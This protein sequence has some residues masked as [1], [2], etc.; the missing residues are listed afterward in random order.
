MTTAHN[1]LTRAKPGHIGGI[2]LLVLCLCIVSTAVARDTGTGLLRLQ[3][4][5]LEIK[6]YTY[7]P[8]TCTKPSLLFVFHGLKRNA[9]SYRNKAMDIASRAC[10]MVFAP[11]FDKD[12]FPNWRYQRA[13]V[14]RKGHVQ[15]RSQ[16]T[17]PVLRALLDLA[18]NQ[19]NNPDAK[20]YLFG[21]SAGAQFL[22]RISAYSPLS[23]VDRVVIANPSVHVAP[24]LSEDA[25]Y[26][27]GGVSSAEQVEAD[28]MAYL[29]SPI[30]IYLGQ[31]DTGEK[32]LVKSAAAMRQGKNRFERG[33]RIFSMA[34]ELARLRGW[35]FEWQLVEVPGVGHSSGKMLRAPELYLALGL[36]SRTPKIFDS[37]AHLLKPET[38]AKNIAP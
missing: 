15:P 24:L 35:P 34:Q 22:S 17:A 2:L 8:P 6:V 3:A 19:V 4:N 11:T 33:R 27:F 23:G 26:G 14:V 1:I 5:G 16:W 20:L 36:H 21:H 10:F 28:L 31:E 18:R 7:R 12:R 29:A 13:G 32:Y 38:Q 25:P 37:P 9:E 30:T